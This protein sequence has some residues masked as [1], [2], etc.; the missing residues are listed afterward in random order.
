ML[1]ARNDKNE[2]QENTWYLDTSAS[3]HM[4]GRR[5]MFMEID[6]SMSENISFGDDSKVTVKGRKNPYSLE[7]WGTSIYFQYLLHTHNENKYF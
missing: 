6:E 7:R 3:N 2:C 4:C 5:S 1:L